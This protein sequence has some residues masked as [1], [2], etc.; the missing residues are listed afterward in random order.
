MRIINIIVEAQNNRANI[1]HTVKQTKRENMKLYVTRI[2]NWFYA[3][4]GNNLEALKCGAT[5]VNVSMTT[6]G[7]STL[8]R[9]W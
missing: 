9:Q 4:D 3:A 7:W 5:V 8:C 2:N 1:I 6:S